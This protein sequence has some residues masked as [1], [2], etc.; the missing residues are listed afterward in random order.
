MLKNVNMPCTYSSNH[1]R[2]P[3]GTDFTGFTPGIRGTAAFVVRTIE[4][5]GNFKVPGSDLFGDPARFVKCRIQGHYADKSPDQLVSLFCDDLG[6]LAGI[7]QAPE[8][9]DVVSG[10]PSEST[11]EST[12]DKVRAA[13]NL[14][15][16]AGFLITEAK[17]TFDTFMTYLMNQ[18][19]KCSAD[20]GD[21][22]FYCLKLNDDNFSFEA[23]QEFKK[24]IEDEGLYDRSW[25]AGIIPNKELERTGGKVPVSWLPI[26]G[27]RDK[28]ETKWLQNGTPSSAV[29]EVL[30]DRRMGLKKRIDYFTVPAEEALS[31]NDL[32]AALE[33]QLDLPCK[34]KNNYKKGDFLETTLDF[35]REECEKFGSIP[36]SSGYYIV[37]LINNKFVINKKKFG[38][39]EK[40]VNF[41]KENKEYRAN[42]GEATEVLK[43]AGIQ[44]NEADSYRH[45]RAMQITQLLDDTFDY[46]RYDDAQDIG[47]YL[48]DRI[49]SELSDPEDVAEVLEQLLDDNGIRASYE[50]VMRL[51]NKI[52][53]DISKL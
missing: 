25:V 41:F 43:R 20:G 8:R 33:S 29:S 45:E 7:D 21:H 24:Q 37:W 12:E 27:R 22:T 14:L 39:V 5:E 38:S 30:A 44:I 3:D 42:L 10:Q 51:A 52:V 11:A 47:D 46:L 2:F 50:L 6:P 1:L 35:S 48:A 31:L 4:N 40:V 36:T 53:H 16:S 23:Y 19:G 34:I 17:K 28:Y 13:R 15:E 32:K 9:V 26:F 49:P 18:D